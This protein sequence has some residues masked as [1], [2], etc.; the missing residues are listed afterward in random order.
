VHFVFNENGKGAGVSLSGTDGKDV[1]FATG[2]N[3]TLSGGKGSDQFVFA[4]SSSV[5][6]DTIQGF[7]HG[8]DLIDLRAFGATID[9]ANV[10]Q[11]LNQNLAKHEPHSGDLLLTLDGNDSVLLKGTQSLQVGDFIVSPHVT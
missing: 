9:A 2:Y 7:S 6:H 10:Q 11:W 4:P 3:D 1:I 8:Q 5:N